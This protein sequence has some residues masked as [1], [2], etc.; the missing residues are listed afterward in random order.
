MRVESL[1]WLHEGRARPKR[2]VTVI[3]VIEEMNRGRRDLE[4][5]ASSIDAAALQNEMAKRLGLKVT[6]APSK[7]QVQKKADQHTCPSCD[8]RMGETVQEYCIQCGY[9]APRQQATSSEPSLAFRR[10]LI[11]IPPKATPDIMKPIDWYFME[12]QITRKV[13]PDICCPICMEKFNRGEEVLLSCGHIFHKVCL[14]SFE[15]FVKTAELSC[16]IC[17][18]KNYQKKLTN[19]G[20]FSL[21]KV[22]ASKIQAICRGYLTRKEYKRMLRRMYRSGKGTETLRTK[23]LQN[24]CAVVSQRMDKTM[25][26]RATQVDSMLRSMDRTLQDS[27]QLDLLFEQMLFRR[28][29]TSDQGQASGASYPPSPEHDKTVPVQDGASSSETFF[30]LEVCLSTGTYWGDILKQA[31]ARGENDCA[32]CMSSVP[33]EPIPSLHKKKTIVLSCSHL[34]H[35]SCIVSFEKFAQQMQVSG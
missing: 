32:I 35:Q 26:N 21:E 19:L 20:N 17:R 5:A 23:F 7:R 4:A 8:A 13:D 34:F 2:I 33:A 30:A 18:T 1:V 6:G 28:Q 27:R 29:Q 14:R 11:P 31:K 15:N 25:E 22:S 12:S 3:I 16:P 10:G 9:G 24:E